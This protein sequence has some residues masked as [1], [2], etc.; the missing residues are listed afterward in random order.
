MG[1][2]KNEPQNIAYKDTRPEEERNHCSVEGAI[3]STRE[4]KTLGRRVESTAQ[5]ESR[6][7]AALQ[8]RPNT[9]PIDQILAKGVTRPSCQLGLFERTVF[10]MHMNTPHIMGAAAGVYHRC[11]HLLQ[12][13]PFPVSQGNKSA[14]PKH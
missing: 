8:N 11:V 4:N 10:T 14:I 6:P 12:L 9:L 2:K 3:S 5:W 1:H 13:T 7:S